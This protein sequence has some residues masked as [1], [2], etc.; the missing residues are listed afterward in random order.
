MSFAKSIWSL[1]WSAGL[2]VALTKSPVPPQV[3]GGWIVS[4]LPFYNSASYTFENGLPDGL[5]IANWPTG[6]NWQAD[7]ANV[8][9]NNGYLE[10]WVPG[11]QNPPAG[12]RYSGAEV[13]TVA[14]NIAY[15]SFRTVAILTQTPGVCNGKFM[16]VFAT[17][18]HT[19]SEPSLIAVPS[20]NVH[21]P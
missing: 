1:V 9:F 6:L 17:V 20:R 18:R 21:I 10:L 3:D 12:T 19:A 16:P 7:A 4:D 14:K 13:D 2:S 5:I 15:G 8:K 11:A